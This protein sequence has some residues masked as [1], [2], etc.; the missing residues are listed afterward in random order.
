MARKYYKSAIIPLPQR[1]RIAACPPGRA[2]NFDRG[3]TAE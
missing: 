3:L 2:L 1:M